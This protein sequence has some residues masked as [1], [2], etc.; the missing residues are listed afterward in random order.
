MHI[1]Y[2]VIRPLV[3]IHIACRK[4]DRARQQAQQGRELQL[5]FLFPP[6]RAAV[7]LFPCGL[8]LDLLSKLLRYNGLKL[9]RTEFSI[10]PVKVISGTAVVLS[11]PFA[12]EI[13]HLALQRFEFCKHFGVA[14]AEGCFQLLGDALIGSLVAKEKQHVGRVETAL[15][16]S[17]IDNLHLSHR[18]ARRIFE[19]V[20]ILSGKA[21][22][23]LLP[24]LHRRNPAVALPDKA[25]EER[26]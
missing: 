8:K 14:I 26:S 23:E 15:G 7:L 24:A 6:A 22:N 3:S 21:V 11:G 13:L 18:A 4:L 9:F 10:L 20:P 19:Q 1:A 25:Y 17:T 12:E 5:P 2:G 16:Q